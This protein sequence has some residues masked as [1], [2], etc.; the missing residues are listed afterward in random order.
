MVSISDHPRF[1]SDVLRPLCLAAALILAPVITT[2][3]AHAQVET[4]PAGHPVYAFLKRMEV[5]GHIGRY[6]DAVLPLSRANVASL[7]TEA[8]AQP[9]VLTAAEQEI[10]ND[11][12]SEFR[13]ELGDSIAGLSGAIDPDHYLYDY[14]DSSVSLFFNGLLTLD[15]RR[16]AGDDAGGQRA[17]FLQFGGRVRGTLLGHLGY[18]LQGTNAQFWGSRELLERDPQIAQSY[19]LRTADA[20][21]FDFADGYVRY[22]ARPVSVQI[23][24]ERLLWG[25]GYDQQMV[26]S[27]NPRVFDF[28]RADV[29][30]RSLKYTFLHAW[31]LG[32]RSLLSF[33]LPSDTSSVFTEP[34]VAD[35]YFAAH[36]LEFS[37]GSVIDIGAQ[38]MVVYSNRAPDLAYLNPLTVIESAQRSRE[39]RDNVMWA[40]DIQ[41]R[42]LAGVQLTGT[43]LF[44]DLHLGQ[45]FDD[46]WYNRYGYQAGLMLTDPAGL[47]DVTLMAE[48][49]RIEPY[50]F[51]H[52]RSRENDFGSLGAILGPRIGP[53][54]DAWF[55]GAE[56]VPQ[57]NLRFSASVLL[58]RKGENDVDASGRLLRNV[59]GDILQPHRDSDPERRTFLD[60]ILV[61]TTTLDLRAAW[62]PVNQFWIEAAYNGEFVRRPSD[63]GTSSYHTVVLRARTEL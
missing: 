3:S 10:L 34:V 16:M 12:R 52:N 57:W 19:A 60:G 47:A 35:K 37:F 39:E 55:L 9:E 46:F 17:A 53:N 63:T 8:G 48:Y 26:L 23:G 22:D 24:R 2:V 15:G 61:K 18:Y 38:E 31:L 59:G 43:I 6:F 62:E 49:T 11:F 1:A 4:V 21:N 40:F 56:Y 13:V 44:D 28:I 20:R 27:A 33:S 54:A 30:Y 7:L 50:T 14:R 41:T 5:K 42:F 29:E 45:F 51:A 25:S 58:S 32:R 36:R